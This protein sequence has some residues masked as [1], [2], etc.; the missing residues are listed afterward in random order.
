MEAEIL[1]LLDGL[2]LVQDYGLV[3]YP[4]IIKTDSQVL[5]DLIKQRSKLSWEFWALFRKIFSILHSLEYRIQ[6]SYRE[7][8]AVADS[9]QQGGVCNNA[10]HTHT[11]PLTLTLNLHMRQLLQRDQRKIKSLQSKIKKQREYDGHLFVFSSSTG[12]M[13]RPSSLWIICWLPLAGYSSYASSKR[14][15][16]LLCS[17]LLN[18][19]AGYSSSPLKLC[20]S[21]EAFSHTKGYHLSCSRLICN[22]AALSIGSPR[23]S[24]LIS[25]SLSNPNK[26]I[27]LPYSISPS[28]SHGPAPKTPQLKTTNICS[29]SAAFP[30]W[31]HLSANGRSS[32]KAMYP[33]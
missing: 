28:T 13:S 6:H 18:S 27:Q 29:S 20:G 25:N 31:S 16:I 23:C 5:V 3:V 12:S 26:A 7:G 33:A 2:L 19:M 10:S 32:F 4:L 21:Q 24:W 17:I 9:G 8:N 11:F 22:P 1:A 14:R 15:G 30:G